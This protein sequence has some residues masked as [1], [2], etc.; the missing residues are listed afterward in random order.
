MS[1][2][3]F[4]TEFNQLVQPL[5]EGIAEAAADPVIFDSFRKLNDDNDFLS[6]LRLCESRYQLSLEEANRVYEI[7]CQGG[8]G[9]ETS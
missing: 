4:N 8:R 9:G 5:V 1:Q 7:L 6:F 2:R 3:D